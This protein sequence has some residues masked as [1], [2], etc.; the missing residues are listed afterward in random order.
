MTVFQPLYDVASRLVYECG[1]CAALV[2][3][4]GLGRHRD[5]HDRLERG[6]GGPGVREPRRPYP[7]SGAALAALREVTDVIL[8]DDDPT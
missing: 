3:V 7:P 1:T 8:E 6:D 2:D 5:F 4:T